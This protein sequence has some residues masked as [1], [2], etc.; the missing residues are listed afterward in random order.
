[1]KINYY[2]GD[3]TCMDNPL[4]SFIQ[5][6]K[7]LLLC[8]QKK[9][10]S[11]WKKIWGY[12]NN[13]NWFSVLFSGELLQPTQSGLYE[14]TLEKYIWSSGEIM[15]EVCLQKLALNSWKLYSLSRYFSEEKHREEPQ[16]TKCTWGNVKSGQ[17][18]QSQRYTS[19]LIVS[20]QEKSLLF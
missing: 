12:L 16:Q 7:T 9:T 14:Q 15:R 13:T 11:V 1:M 20:N 3:R 8:A 2:A 18:R 6:Y 4:K 5:T 19:L 10:T 17:A